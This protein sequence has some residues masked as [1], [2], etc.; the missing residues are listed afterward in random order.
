MTVNR[1]TLE[2]VLEL[3]K[4][5]CPEKEVEV[6]LLGEFNKI[7]SLIE[8][9]NNINTHG[10]VPLEHA[11]E[12]RQPLREDK[13]TEVNQREIFQSIAPATKAGFYLVPQVI[14]TQE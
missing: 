14:E 13:V 3:A 2:K 1:E 12:G 10:I 5:T 6:K 4:L 11:I 8:Q 7:L 9:L